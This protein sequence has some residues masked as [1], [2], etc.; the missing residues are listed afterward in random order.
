MV[1]VARVRSLASDSLKSHDPHHLL[2]EANRLYW[3]F[4]SSKAQP[5]YAEAERRFAQAGDQRNALYASVGRIRGQA[6]TMSFVDISAYLQ[7]SF[8]LAP[9]PRFTGCFVVC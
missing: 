5:L 6:G 3:L 7:Q 9:H 1:C 4:N 2:A 8:L